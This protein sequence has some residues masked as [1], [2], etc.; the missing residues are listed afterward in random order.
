M[1]KILFLVITAVFAA[2]HSDD[3]AEPVF[4]NNYLPL[5]VGNY[6]D[7]QRMD[8]PQVTPLIHREV[9]ANVEMDDFKYYLLVTTYGDQSAKDSSYYRIDSNGSAFIYRKNQSKEDNRFHLNGK[10]GDE[11]SYPFEQN[12]EAHVKLSVGSMAIG[13]KTL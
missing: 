9:I 6:W 11:W 2:C 10:D 3:K 12:D 13:N 1:K 7:F 8:Q 5:Q 4:D